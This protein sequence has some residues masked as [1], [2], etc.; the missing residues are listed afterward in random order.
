MGK[1]ADFLNAQRIKLPLMQYKQM[2][3]FDAELEAL[4]AQVT[5][6]RSEIN[7]LKEAKELLGASNPS[8]YACDHCG[9]SQLKR[10]GNR[11]DPM[12]GEVGIKQLVFQCLSCGKE[13]AFTPTS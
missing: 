7:A 12:F 4:E 10:T 3:A 6:Q 9:S 8:D 2:I 1:I 5:E 13:S 11:P